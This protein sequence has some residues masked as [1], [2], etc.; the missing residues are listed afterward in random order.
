M[1]DVTQT[2]AV[3]PDEDRAIDDRRRWNNRPE[4]L[5]EDDFLRGGSQAQPT[6]SPTLEP[7]RNP[8][9][10]WGVVLAATGTVVL[11]L[12]AIITFSVVMGGLVGVLTVA[13]AVVLTVALAVLGAIGVYRGRRIYQGR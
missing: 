2:E 12:A 1:K 6:P 13:E 11:V 4:E 10:D 7:S 5:R 3:D 8:D 9:R